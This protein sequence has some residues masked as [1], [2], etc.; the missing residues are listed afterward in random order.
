VS[1]VVEGL[2]DERVLARGLQPGLGL[3]RVSSPREAGPSPL[4]APA[5]PRDLAF[6]KIIGFARLWLVFVLFF[7]KKDF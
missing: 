3:G 4:H 6:L 7:F 5:G 1:A 2:G